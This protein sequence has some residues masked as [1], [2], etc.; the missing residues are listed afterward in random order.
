[1]TSDLF[2]LRSINDF[3]SLYKAQGQGSTP[4]LA[5]IEPLLQE[6]SR[7]YHLGVHLEVPT[8]KLKQFERD[9][10]RD[11]ARQR[12]E[13][14]TYWR[15]NCSDATWGSLAAAVEKVGGHGNLVRRLRELALESSRQHGDVAGNGPFVRC[16]RV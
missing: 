6:M 5:E 12:T 1:M 3:I 16:R 7:V 15:D 4:S 8:E 11:T 10:P 13:V 9:Y 2:E 14:L